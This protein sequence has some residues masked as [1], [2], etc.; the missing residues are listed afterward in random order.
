MKKDRKRTAI[1]ILSAIAA[2]CFLAELAI[3]FLPKKLPSGSGIRPDRLSKI[4]YV[5]DSGLEDRESISQAA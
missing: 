2:V 1:I 4:K 5:T 3:I